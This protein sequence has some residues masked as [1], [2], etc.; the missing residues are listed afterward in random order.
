MESAFGVDHGE[1]SKRLP[2]AL[3]NADKFASGP[4]NYVNTRLA[5]H[6]Q[7]RTAAKQ[8]TRNIPKEVR[9]QHPKQLA[10]KPSDLGRQNRSTSR[11]FLP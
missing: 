7:G 1:V 6:A 10:G 2:S 9:R 4:N 8:P 11:G 3:R 5:A